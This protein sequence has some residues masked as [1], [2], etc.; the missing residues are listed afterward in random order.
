M[1]KLVM[2]LTA[3]KAEAASFTRSLR[4]SPERATLVTLSGELGAGKTTFVK[5]I[6]K[7]LGIEETVN[8]PTFVLEKIY[9]L[10]EGVPFKRLIH[11]DAYR[12]ERGEDLM[13][14]GFDELMQDSGNLIVLEWPE[15]VDNRLPASAK[16]I[17]IIVRS[18]SARIVSYG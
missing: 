7:E 2:S 10:P 3:F 18:D 6:A 16:K 17:R 12:L 13:A 14:L 4:H 1:R 15:R 5:V 9:L 11:I 8:S